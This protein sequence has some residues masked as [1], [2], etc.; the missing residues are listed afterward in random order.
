MNCPNPNCRSDKVVYT[1]TAVNN[2]EDDGP[3]MYD[4]Y[5][6]A[7]CGE[8]IRV[9]PLNGFILWHMNRKAQ[10]LRVEGFD[11]SEAGA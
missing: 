3:L 7:E 5:E 1:S 11:V 2:W 9:H 6:C 8:V 10:Q 4:L